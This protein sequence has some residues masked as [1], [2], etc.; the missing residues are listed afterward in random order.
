MHSKSHTSELTTWLQAGPW[1]FYN[2][3]TAAI[4]SGPSQ[5]DVL[6]FAIL[7]FM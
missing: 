5:V 6:P 4:L 1:P 3:M 2:N 7:P